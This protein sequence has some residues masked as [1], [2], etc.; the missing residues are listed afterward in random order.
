MRELV[1]NEIEAACGLVA[2]I[3]S[4]CADGQAPFE[5]GFDGLT[6]AKKALVYERARAT[7]NMLT[8]GAVANC[9]VTVRPCAPRCVA[10]SSSWQWSGMTWMPVN[11]GNGV[12]LNLCGCDSMCGC[13]PTGMIDLNG[14]VAEVLE[15]RIDGV[16]VDPETY[17][18]V[19]NR[20]LHSYGDP[21]PTEQDMDV[22]PGSVGT[23]EIDIRTGGVLGLQGEAAYGRLICE[24]AKLECG[25]ECA[26]PKSVRR[27]QRQGV[28]YEIDREA[29][30]G[31]LTSI[32]EV[33]EYLTRVNP[34]AQRRM[35]TVWTPQSKGF[36][37]YR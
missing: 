12:W 9:P 2:N 22:A 14:P 37:V 24:Y 36:R 23:F 4:C 11:V 26:L 34:Y 3:E 8:A 21:W 29:F 18:L 17:G 25:Q 32:R 28:S 16:A 19:D 1:D 27:I 6:N 15:V 20:Y 31:G 5:S 30:P 33:D 7:L 35:T 13:G 10:A